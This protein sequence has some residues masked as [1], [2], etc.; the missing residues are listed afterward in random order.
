VSAFA[1]SRRTAPRR[2]VSRRAAAAS[3]RRWTGRLTTGIWIL[4]AAALA[5]LASFFFVF[6]HD[7][8]TQSPQFNARQIQVEGTRRLSA[9]VVAAQ[10]G[11]R[12]GVNVLG[13][14]LS[15]ARRKLLAHPWIAE[16]EVRREIP[17]AIHIRIREHVPAAVVDIG[18]K[19]LLNE[20]GEIFKEVEP[21]DPQGLPVV[22]GL[23][24]TDVRVADRSGA[25]VPPVTAVLA[26]AAPP[27]APFSRPMEAVL[28]LL[29]LGREAGGILPARQIAAIRVDRELGLTVTAYEDGKSIRLGYDDYA[30]KYRLLGELLAFFKSQPGMAAATRIDLTDAGRV[31]VNPARA[32]LPL[33]PGPKGG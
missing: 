20:Q 11:V 21:A 27:E 14:N 10:A 3:R 24:P 33:K 25:A 32:E 28:Q 4:A 12:E 13:V 6:V 22:S 16:A 26:P 18:R 29:A 9:R 17:S 5:V 19:F 1:A 2:N 8:F 7:V 31:I 15:A 30:A 23:K